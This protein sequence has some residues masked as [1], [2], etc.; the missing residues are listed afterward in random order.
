MAIY[1]RETTANTLVYLV[2]CWLCEFE[3][4]HLSGREYDALMNQVL[5]SGCTADQLAMNDYATIDEIPF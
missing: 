5:C 1:A 2:T 4:V 3:T